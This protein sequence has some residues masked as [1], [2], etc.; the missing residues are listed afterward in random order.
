MPTNKNFSKSGPPAY[1]ADF[2]PYGQEI[3]YTARLQTTACPPNYKFTGYERDSETGLDYAFARYYSS[4]LGSFLST[5]P[6]GG[7]IGDL[8]SHNAYAYTRNNPLNSTDPSGMSD[9]PDLKF[10][11]SDWL[12][13]F[14]A[15]GVDLF[16]GTPGD[17]L[18][19]AWADFWG[20]DCAIENR[21]ANNVLANIGQLQ[22][23]FFLDSLIPPINGFVGDDCNG[24]P[25]T[26]FSS[27]VGNG[28]FVSGSYY[29]V[30]DIGGQYNIPSLSISSP[31]GPG[32]DGTDV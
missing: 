13:L 27:Y 20:G 10:E 8:Q 14:G 16:G 29:T 23:Q 28:C 7:S 15:A 6:L 24:G 18:A 19:C 5:D 32:S 1:D 26:P 17:P 22:L 4:H 3:S 12:G 21:M 2:T 9:C 31:G 25:C 30:T 11:C